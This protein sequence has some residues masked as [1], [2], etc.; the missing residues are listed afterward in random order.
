MAFIETRIRDKIAYNFQAVPT[1]STRIVTLDNGEESRNAN[2]TKAKRRYAALYQTFNE[3][4]FAALLATFHACN[5]SAKGFRFKDFTDYKATAEVIGVAPAGSTPVQLVKSYPF[6]AVTKTR[7]ILKP[8]AAGFTF[9][10]NGTPKA[11]TLDTT[12]GIFTPTTAW[13]GSAVLS[14]TGEF[15]VPVRFASD[16]FPAT[17]VQFQA[18][19]T[20]IE[21]IEIFRA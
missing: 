11:G 5:G 19:E 16:E 1:Y 12:T 10:Q 17:Y 18:I 21:L 2:W 7:T 15:D 6:G 4:D 9:Y 20:Q 3:A 14:W 13:T 8:V